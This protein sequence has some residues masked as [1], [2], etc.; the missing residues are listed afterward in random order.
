MGWDESSLRMTHFCCNLLQHWILQFCAHQQAYA[1][2]ITWKGLIRKG[3]DSVHAVGCRHLGGVAWNETKQ[4]EISKPLTVRCGQHQPELNAFIAALSDIIGAKIRLI[5]LWNLA[6]HSY[7][8]FPIRSKFRNRWRRWLRLS[9]WFSP[10][11]SCLLP[12]SITTLNTS[13]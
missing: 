7:Q 6:T 10:R 1:S 9:I 8:I 4:G 2:R 3:V 11:D 5:L 13:R 12:T